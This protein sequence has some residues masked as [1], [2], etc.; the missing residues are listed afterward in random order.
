MVV[1]PATTHWDVSMMLCPPFRQRAAIQQKIAEKSLYYCQ[2][3][4]SQTDACVE[5][6]LTIAE[7]A[8]YPQLKARGIVIDVNRG[9]RNLKQ[10]AI[11]HHFKSLNK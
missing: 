7:A 4:F 9:D 10:A 5:P 6:V 3:V 2:E 11:C 1:L 8:E